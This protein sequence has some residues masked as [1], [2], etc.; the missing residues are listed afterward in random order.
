MK[1]TAGVHAPAAEAPVAGEEFNPKYVRYV[2]LLIF[3]VTVFNI[4]DR[5]IISVLVDD[6]RA[7]MA[8]DDRQMGFVMGMAFSITYFVAGIPIARLADR[9]SRK[10]IVSAALV[11]WSVMTAL[12]G[13]AQTFWQL[14]IARMGVGIGEAGGSP[15]SQSLITDYVPPERLSRAMSVIIIGAMVGG[16]FGVVFGGWAGTQY[17]WRM[18]LLFVSVP[19]L[20]LGVLFYLTVREPPRRASATASEAISG[21]LLEAL[22]LLKRIP[23]YVHLTLAASFVA[24]VSTGRQLWEPTFIRRVY[25]LSA[26]DAG[27][28]YM[29]ISIVPGVV[30]AYLLSVTM[31]KLA[32]RDQRWYAWVPALC[33]LVT[34]PL[35]LAFYASDP[36]SLFFGVPVGYLYSVLA[37]LSVAAWAPATMTLAQKV[38][39]ADIRAVS[40]ATWSLIS[41]LV[42]AGLGPL[43]IGDLNTRLESVYAQEAIRYSLS[44]VAIISVL[45]CF[46]YVMVARSLDRAVVDADQGE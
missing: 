37:S 3:L 13:Q 24:L 1:K 27:L 44:A 31:D 7:D 23:A 45:A 2:L 16:G 43:L 5:T 19:G 42:G 38:V 22:L 39:P 14:V 29:L 41:G 33:I 18:A 25:D 34:I 15:P 17:G 36:Q 9:S 26:Q 11:V 32:E 30:G 40:A 21:N 4:C 28:T 8:L 35:S 6:I 20:A 10:L 46:F 12:T